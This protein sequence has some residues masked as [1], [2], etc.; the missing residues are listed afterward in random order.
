MKNKKPQIFGNIICHQSGIPYMLIVVVEN[1]TREIPVSNSSLKTVKRAAKDIYG[2][3]DLL[4]SLMQD[5]Q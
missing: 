1:L 2:V 5:G 4:I 3:T